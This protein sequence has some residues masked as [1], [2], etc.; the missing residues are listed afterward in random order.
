VLVAAGVVVGLV[1]GVG[2]ILLATRFMPGQ[3]VSVVPW[4]AATVAAAAG[5]AVGVP[6]ARVLVMWWMVLAGAALSM[7]DLATQLLPNRMI[8]PAGAVGLGL[9]VLVSA[10]RGE[11]W[12]L[13]GGLGGALMGLVPLYVAWLVAPPEAI[14]FGDVRLATVLGLHL[15]VLTATAILVALV[16]GMLAGVLVTTALTLARRR[17]WR[18]P[19][20]LGPYLVLGAVVVA[21]AGA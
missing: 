13:L 19:F 15:G 14:G 9:V 5:V 8:Y 7:V 20:P 1:G 2:A 16:V 21:V 18:D 11:P 12:E 4:L 10:L 3:G 6:D 17:T